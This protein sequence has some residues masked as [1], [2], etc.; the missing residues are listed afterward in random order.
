MLND[1]FRVSV[2]TPAENDLLVR[3]LR[4]ILT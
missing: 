3:A 4:E 1:Y 2:G